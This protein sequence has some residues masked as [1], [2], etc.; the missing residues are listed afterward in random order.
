MQTVLVLKELRGANS[1]LIDEEIEMMEQETTKESE[2][3]SI[4][5]ILKDPLLRLPVVLILLIPLCMQMS[6]LNAVS[7][8]TNHKL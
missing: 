1:P 2:R 6:G 5:S 7:D 3:R 8:Q 4:W